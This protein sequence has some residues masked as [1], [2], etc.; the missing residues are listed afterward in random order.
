[1]TEREKRIPLYALQRCT[2]V[3]GPDAGEF[4]P[5]RW[6]RMSAEAAPGSA[7]AAAEAETDDVVKAAAT[8]AA[9]GWLP[10]SEGPRNCVGMSLALM[11]LRAALAL[12]CGRFRSAPPGGPIRGQ[13]QAGLGSLHST[14]SHPYLRARRGHTGGLRACSRPEYQRSAV[15][16]CGASPS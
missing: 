3:W 13:Q 6:L 15:R 11:E 14:T 2:H 12:L 16:A 4:R 1:M 10:F 7:A 9:R 5:E 8:Q